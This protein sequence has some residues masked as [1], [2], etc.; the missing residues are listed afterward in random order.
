MVVWWSLGNCSQI[1]FEPG[2]G[3]YQGLAQKIKAPFSLIFRLFPQFL[4]FEG[5]FKTRA[6]PR[7]TPNSSWNAFRCLVAGWGQKIAKWY[8]KWISGQ[9]PT[10]MDGVRRVGAVPKPYFREV[11]VLTIGQWRAYRMHPSENNF[12][13][14]FVPV[15]YQERKGHVSLRKSPGHRPGVPAHLA[16]QTGVY[17]PVSLREKLKGNN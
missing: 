9:Q 8:V 3:A 1:S 10:K 6:K 13:I 2:F 7:Y 4:G 12:W 11:S 5:D 14:H 16:G 17:R 15:T